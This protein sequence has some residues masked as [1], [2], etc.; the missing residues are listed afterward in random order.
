MDSGF[1]DRLAGLL[2][3]QN[4]DFEGL[5]I[6]GLERVFGGNSR[7]AWAFD[8][9]FQQ[10]EKAR[11]MACIVLSQVPGRH[12]ESDT[13][14]EYSVLRAMTGQGLCAPGAV[15]LDVEGVITGAPAVIMER[16]EGEASAVD[17][18]NNPED[19]IGKALTTEL[20]E[21]TADLHHFDWQA[22]GLQGSAESAYQELL[23][24]ETRFLENRQEPLPAMQYVLQ[25]LKRNFPQPA[26]LSLV[27]GDLRPGNFLYQGDRI[28][29]ILDWEMAHIGDPA[30]DIGWI[31]RDLW[32]PAR[33][34]LLG[35]FLSV[36][37]GRHGFDP[38]M[39][40]V[41]YYRIFSEMKFAVISI[42]ASKAVSSGKTLNMRH[43]DRASKVPKCL[44]LC[45]EFI[46]CFRQVSRDA[47][48]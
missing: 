39:K 16:V 44:Q 7:L 40:N 3:Q 26:R 24:W 33:F 10:A 48:A 9:S 23:Q 8:L 41:I 46:E 11:Q 30:E 38:G 32:S 35:E 1:T 25:W 45:F 17:F 14:V 22:A 29:A 18:L 28:T 12:V 2:Q 15:A 27:H 20:A 19:A 6:A 43:V 42:T 37:S 21:K 47:E 4:P 5:S 31:Y 34:M 36:Y 13:G